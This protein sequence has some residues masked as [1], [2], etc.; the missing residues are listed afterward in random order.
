MSSSEPAWKPSVAWSPF[1]ERWTIRSSVQPTGTIVIPL[2]WINSSLWNSI[3]GTRNW[4]RQRTSRWWLRGRLGI[5]LYFWVSALEV[6]WL[7][8]SWTILNPSAEILKFRNLH[9]LM[10]SVIRILFLS[11]INDSNL[12]LQPLIIVI[13]ALHAI[14]RGERW[15]ILHCLNFFEYTLQSQSKVR[16]G[17]WKEV[18]HS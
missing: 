8:D 7:W 4:H 5:S 13:V 18:R 15:E 3:D 10:K 9:S 16:C 6:T 1:I 2:D 12:T 14:L 17:D 11:V